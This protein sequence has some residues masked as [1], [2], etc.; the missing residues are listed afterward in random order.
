[1]ISS[2]YHSLRKTLQQHQ[3]GGSSDDHRDLQEKLQQRT[4][5]GPDVLFLHDSLGDRINPTILKREGLHT[6]KKQTYTLEDS[7]R[8]V[9]NLKVAPRVMAIHVGTNNLPRQSID[10]ILDLYNNLLTLIHS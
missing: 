8:Y 3:N 1:M 9:N 10:E 6:A 2:I 5:N 4:S 7:F